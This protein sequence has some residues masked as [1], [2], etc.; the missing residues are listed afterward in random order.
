LHI[1]EDQK[2][3]NKLQETETKTGIKTETVYIK[4]DTQLKTVDDVGKKLGTLTRYVFYAPI[5]IAA[6][7][8]NYAHIAEDEEEHKAEK[9]LNHI[10][11]KSELSSFS[12]SSSSSSSSI[13]NLATLDKPEP[14]DWK[15]QDKCYFCVDG[16]LLKVNEVGELVA[17][18]GSVRPEIELNKHVSC[19]L[20][21]RAKTR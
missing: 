20:N 15:P 16:N 10:R 1:A 5:L 13:G 11:V 8:L 6:F 17:E 2:N 19:L 7:F 18:L 14:I 12:S 3:S 21:P 4:E 9:D